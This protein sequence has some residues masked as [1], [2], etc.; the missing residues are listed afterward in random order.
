MKNKITIKKLSAI[1][2]EAGNENNTEITSA[3]A[4]AMMNYGYVMSEELFGA[5][6]AIPTKKIKELFHDVMSTLEKIKGFD[7][8]YKAMY[9][10]FPEQVMK[11]SRTELFINATSHYWSLGKWLPKYD[12]LKR[13][14][15]L[16]TQKTQ[17]ISLASKEQYLAIFTGIIGSNESISDEDKEMLEYFL[18]TEKELKFPEEIPFKENMCIVAGFLLK[19]GRSITS[20]TKTATDILRIMTYLSEGD[21]SLASNTKFK[22]FSR[23]ERRYFTK[24][25][26]KVASEE[27]IYR[28][29]KKWIRAFHSL[30]V[31]DYSEKVFAMAK[32]FR[33][34]EKVETFN[35]KVQYAL[36]NGNLPELMSLLKTRAGEFTR[37]LDHVL[38]SFPKQQESIV[39]SFIGVCYEVSTRVLLQALGHFFSR[40][41]ELGDRIVFPKGKVQHAKRLDSSLESLDERIV[42]MICDGIESALKKRFADLPSL[43]KTWIDPAL[44]NCPI[45]SQMR[46]AS[47]GSFSVARGTQLPLGSEEKNTL[48][49]FVYWIGQDIDLSA[50]LHDANF[51]L[52]EKISYTNLRSAKY[53]ACHSG[54][55]THA[56]APKG[57]SEFIDITLDQAAACGARY[58]AMNVLVYSGPNFSEHEK[59]YAG[60][61]M[62]E[63]PKSNEIYEAKSVLQKVELRG[64]CRNMIPAV[65]DTVERKMI[66]CDLATSSRTNWGGNN[67]ESNAATIEETLRNIVSAKNKVSLYQLFHLHAEA[68]G[69]IVTNK[70]DAENTFSIDEG[71]TP[72]SINEISSD[73]I[74]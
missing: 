74:A 16:E 61:M 10:N 20:L 22:S 54:D 66:Y 63:K 50:T 14:L 29:R 6:K 60:W 55:I 31:G 44:G 64:E 48:R 28:H 37:K 56:P 34:N 8:S 11:A 36:E 2:V 69:E 65:F 71:I 9:P 17:E 32:K 72:Y 1:V 40:A 27:D 73:F 51:G 52:I 39:R 19:E 67:V 53:Q 70:E 12:E 62:R 3:F 47:E 18:K 7:V 38:R 57:A 45:P 25:I 5:I 33:N 46:S 21:V 23:K 68:R 13:E 49:F 43:G 42:L 59:C 26:E 30:H 24:L 4:A 15:H 35:G 41:D 58:V